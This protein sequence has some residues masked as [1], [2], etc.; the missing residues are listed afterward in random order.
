MKLS[1][2]ERARGMS[3]FE[4]QAPQVELKIGIIRVQPDGRFEIGLGERPFAV[5]PVEVAALDI[6]F[7]VVRVL[8]DFSVELIEFETDLLMRPTWRRDRQRGADT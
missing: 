6:E 5:Q 3:R 8:G 2:A 7:G 1:S 4:P